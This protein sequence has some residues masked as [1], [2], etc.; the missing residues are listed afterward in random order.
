MDKNVKKINDILGNLFQMV[1]KLEEEAVKESTSADLSITE[2]HTLVAVGTGRART[3]THVA[4]LL[5]IRVSTLTAAIN[6]LVKKGYVDRRR[7][8]E[9]RRIVKIQLTE[10]GASAVMAHEDFH[11]AMV[12]EAIAPVPAAELSRFISSLDNIN[13]FLLMRSSMGYRRSGAFTLRPLK[14]G[15]HALP[16]PIVSAGMSIGIA[17]SGLA[18]A[19]AIEGGLGL[20]GTSAIGYRMEEYGSNPQAANLKAIE[21][22]VRVALAAVQKAGGKGLIGVSIM[23]NK[24]WAHQ[25][26][27]TAVKAGAQVIVT[28][29]GIPTDL[30]KYCS[31]KK[32]ALI[33]TISS[34][35]AAS[36]IIRSWAKKYNREPDGFIFQGPLAAGLLGFKETQIEKAEQEWLKLIAD[37]KAELSKLE[38]CPLI[39]GGG[40][41]EKADAEPLYRY[42]ADGFLLGTRF[43]ATEECGA[44]DSYKKLYLNCTAN[45]VTMI[46][47]PMKT[48]VR[49][50]RNAFTQRITDTDNDSYDIIEA[51]LRGAGGDYEN[52]LVFCNANVER[53]RKIDSVKDVFREFTT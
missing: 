35:R 23:W 47:S 17:D 14:L 43:V 39:A 12:S 24:A 3:M 9:D 8:D 32:V 46:K 34:K 53:I 49:V 42:G 15:V 41:I 2:I 7:D 45:D 37:I 26:A 38:N 40:I 51:V 19:V 22:E 21:Q 48:S 25:Y 50:M 33:P 4:N 18:S 10:K 13:Q 36:A 16:V 30:P 11:E 20:I 27:E 31:S 28:S 6:K 1:L 29:A 44:S 5:G 52:S